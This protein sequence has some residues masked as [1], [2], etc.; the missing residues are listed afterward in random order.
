MA[1]RPAKRRQVDRVRVVVFLTEKSYRQ[2][3]ALADSMNIH[4][5]AVVA[6]AIARIHRSEVKQG[7][8]AHSE[9]TNGKAATE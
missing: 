7:R 5:S 8:L 3:E 1:A 2:M 6:F 4:R 9:P